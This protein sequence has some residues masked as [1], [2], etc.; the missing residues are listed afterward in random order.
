[1]FGVDLQSQPCSYAFSLHSFQWYCPDCL[2]TASS[3]SSKP[4][5]IEWKDP[6]NKRKSSRSTTQSQ[7]HIN[8]G[9]LNEGFAPDPSRFHKLAQS[10]TLTPHNF[11]SMKGTELTAEW[12]WS[13]PH[14]MTQ[15]ILIES[16]KGLD[17]KV[18]Q[19]PCK[20]LLE[21]YSRERTFP[22]KLMG[23]NA[24]DFRSCSRGGRCGWARHACRSHRWVDNHCKE[25]LTRQRLIRRLGQ[26]WP[27]NPIWRI[28]T[29]ARLPNTSEPYRDS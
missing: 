4:L 9:N 3:S 27:R 8:Y 24:L 10:K 12:L 23:N 26:T 13:D 7:Q 14:A 1:M 28:G 2:K 5:Q 19:D 21:K 16:P 15:P 17:L 18:P 22:V 20:R 6:V 25:S 11:N 29:W